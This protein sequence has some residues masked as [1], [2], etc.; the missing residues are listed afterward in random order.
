[1][2]TRIN[3]FFI[4][5]FVA[6]KI[7]P[8]TCII[9]ELKHFFSHEFTNEIFIREFVAKNFGHK[10]AP[11]ISGAFSFLFKLV[12]YRTEQGSQIAELFHRSLLV[13]I[14]LIS[15]YRISQ[16]RKTPLQNHR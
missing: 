1:M 16:H 4:R 10:K 11:G 9:L 13:S 15:R 7:G 14:L 5:A 6:N 3:C 2:N 12:L 8:T